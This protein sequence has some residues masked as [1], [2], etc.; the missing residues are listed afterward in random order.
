MKNLMTN[1]DKFC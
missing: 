1:Q